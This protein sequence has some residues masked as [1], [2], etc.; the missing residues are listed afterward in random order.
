MAEPLRSWTEETLK[1]EN[2]ARIAEE[3]LLETACWHRVVGNTG[4][5]SQVATRV[6][7]EKE[8]SASGSHIAACP[9]TMSVA[10]VC[11]FCHVA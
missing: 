3:F 7:V 11:L 6:E 8:T 1:L 10:V 9:T 4:L 2:L 5:G